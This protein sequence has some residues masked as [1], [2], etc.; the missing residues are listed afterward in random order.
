[1]SNVKIAI[2]MDDGST[3]IMAFIVRGRGDSLPAG[4]TWS[5]A[6]GWWDREPSDSNIFSEISRAFAGSAAQPTGYRV[7]R[8]SD[9]P[10]DRTYRG[11]LSDD[12]GRLYHDLSRARELHRGKLRRARV[13]LFAENDAA[14]LS[15]MADG[16]GAAID[17]AKARRRQLRDAPADP[18]IDA[19]R[20]TDELKAVS[21]S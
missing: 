1:M 19:A 21:I 14:L 9:I 12:G 13:A 15:A 18:R 17:E 11:A 16:D 8:D 4:A 3:A 2:K 7:V 6:P 5:V 20:T 10:A